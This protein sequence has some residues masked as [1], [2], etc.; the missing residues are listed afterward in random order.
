MFALAA[1]AVGAFMAFVA[2][3]SAMAVTELEEVVLCKENVDPCPLVPTSKHFLS[4][5]VLHGVSKDPILLGVKNILCKESTVLG[6]TTEL[7]A[8]GKITALGWVDCTS[9][10]TESCT[11]TS[12]NLPYLILGKL[13][14]THNGYE[15]VAEKFSGGG[16]PQA[17]VSCPNVSCKYGAATVLMTASVVGGATVLT[18]NATLAGQGIC[19]F[20]SGTWQAAYTVKC[21][22][23][24]AEVNCYLVMET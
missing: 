18:A 9:G 20:T 16:N 22:E 5:T 24:G 17:K 4:G 12:E 13:N 15:T 21:L 3:T 8:H 2:A 19:F 6:E 14:S 1:I 10:G 11:V 23:G 7:L